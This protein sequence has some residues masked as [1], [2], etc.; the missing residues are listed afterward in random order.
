MVWDLKI[1]EEGVSRSDGTLRYTDRTVGVTGLFL[2]EA[3]PVLRTPR[4]QPRQAWIGR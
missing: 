1:I 3:V 2:E 4:Q